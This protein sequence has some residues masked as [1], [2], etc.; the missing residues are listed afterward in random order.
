MLELGHNY[1][2]LVFAAVKMALDMFQHDK[3]ASQREK[4]L[5]RSV[6]VRTDD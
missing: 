1:H 3:S 2:E 5:F 4:D 6:K